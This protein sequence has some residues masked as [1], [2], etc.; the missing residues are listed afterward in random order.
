MDEDGEKK[1]AIYIPAVIF[2]QQ[3]QHISNGRYELEKPFISNDETC[4]RRL[5]TTR[6]TDFAHPS[7]LAHHQLGAVWLADRLGHHLLYTLA[8]PVRHS[9]WPENDYMMRFVLIVLC[10]G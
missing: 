2:S 7:R 4:V 6:T 3:T 8:E 1:I 10:G 5:R 9:T